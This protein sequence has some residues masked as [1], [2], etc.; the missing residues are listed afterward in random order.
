MGEIVIDQMQFAAEME[1]LFGSFCKAKNAATIKV[2]FNGVEGMELS[3]VRKVFQG[4]IK[5]EEF[6]RNYKAFKIACDKVR[7]IGKV[8]SVERARKGCNHCQDGYVFYLRGDK[9]YSGRCSICETRSGVGPLVDPR[10]V[11]LAIKHSTDFEPLNP[12]ENL[13]IL[14]ENKGV[15]MFMGGKSDAANE[16]KR[17]KSMEK[18]AFIERDSLYKQDVQEQKKWAF[19]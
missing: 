1:L 15:A 19:A 9:E 12:K 6:P 17:R 18:E 14:R 8:K 13:A 7:N 4:L 11:K 16:A 3:E 2:W 10:L 5:G